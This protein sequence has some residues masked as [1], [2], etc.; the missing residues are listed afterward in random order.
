MK[1]KNGITSFG[2]L[3]L[4]SLRRIGSRLQSVMPLTLRGK[5]GSSFQ[6][7]KAMVCTT[8]GTYSIKSEADESVADR[9][10]DEFQVRVALELASHHSLSAPKLIETRP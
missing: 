8:E 5:S 2:N 4:Q 3:I 9:V 1:L 7:I 6:K 10:L